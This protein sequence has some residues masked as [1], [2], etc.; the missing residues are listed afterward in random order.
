MRNTFLL[1]FL[2]FIIKFYAN[3]TCK[4]DTKLGI[5]FS[6]FIRYDVMLDTR[7]T[8]ASREGYYLLYPAKPVYDINNRDINASPGLN[9]FT[10][11][12][13]LRLA[14]TG[15]KVFRAASS[16]FFEVDFWGSEVNKLV[17]L[18]HIRL[19]HAWVKFNWNTTELLVGQY[20]H[21]MSITGFFPRPASSNS[22]VPFHP[23]SRNPQIR[24]M[25]SVGMMKF[26]GSILSQRDFPGTGPE[27]PDSKYLRNSAIP[28]IHFQMQCG[29][30][31]S[32]IMAGAGIDY[33]KIVP[34]LST[35]NDQNEII[36][37]GNSLSALSYTGFF[38]ADT[39]H[40][41]VRAQGVYARNAHDILLIGGYGVKEI[42]NINT[43]VK[44][45]S[46]LN[47][48]SAWCD[49]QT[50]GNKISLGIF[51]GYTKN[52][53][54]GGILS[55]PIY[56]RGIDIGSVWRISPRLVYRRN[57]VMISLEGEYTT[58][59]YGTPNGD[60]KGG[61]TDTNP[62]SNLRTVLSFRYFF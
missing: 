43:G 56:A 31:S 58:A 39:K 11:N 26:I 41:S 1:I 30:D 15:P 46:N 48:L 40:L 6:G 12:S 24:I 2:F 62:V 14:L 54:S 44:E 18:N 57:P 51:S 23:I 33:K 19:R 25:H 7:Q 34:E 28:N 36:K 4:E 13:W 16:A 17:D 22:G 55:G 3:A 20:W 8:V 37:T 59:N 9:M 53:G 49:I 42:T 5:K 50:T 47:T 10:I 38:K 52:M 61:V 27:G 32:G 29:E 60:M 35:V 21:P 45:F